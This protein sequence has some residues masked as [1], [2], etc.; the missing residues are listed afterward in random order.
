MCE[1]A[2]DECFEGVR[3]LLRYSMADGGI[4]LGGQLRLRRRFEAGLR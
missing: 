4:L 2:G 3:E 1:E